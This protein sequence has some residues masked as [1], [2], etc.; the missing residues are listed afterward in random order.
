MNQEND[1]KSQHWARQR[2]NEEVF[3]GLVAGVSKD[4]QPQGLNLQIAIPLIWFAAHDLLK[5]AKSGRSSPR[6]RTV[7]PAHKPA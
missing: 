5:S 7:A 6:V 2:V 3:R 1:D 4:N